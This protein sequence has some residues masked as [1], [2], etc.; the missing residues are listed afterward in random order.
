[1][2]HETNIYRVLVLCHQS[3]VLTGYFVL[4]YTETDML[5]PLSHVLSVEL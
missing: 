1:M 2:Y 4:P 5:V 3:F